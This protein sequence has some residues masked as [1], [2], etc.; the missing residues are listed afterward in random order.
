MTY[1]TGS[2]QECVGP[3]FSRAGGVRNM[4]AV[5]SHSVVGEQETRLPAQLQLRFV[6][7]TENKLPHFHSYDTNLRYSNRNYEKAKRTNLRETSAI[8]CSPKII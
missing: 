3:V 7:G 1:V 6:F 2:M 8:G 5:L 4:T